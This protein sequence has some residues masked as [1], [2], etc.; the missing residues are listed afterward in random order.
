MIKKVTFKPY[1]GV[2]YKGG[3]DV[4]R[5]KTSYDK[6]VE[7]SKKNGLPLP[8]YTNREFIGWWLEAMKDFIGTWPTCGR[9][10]HKK[11]YS[12]DN[13]MLQ[14]RKDNSSEGAIRTRHLRRAKRF[15][16]VLCKKTGQHIATFSNTYEAADFFDVPRSTFGKML[17]NYHEMRFVKQRLKFDFK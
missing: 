3:K 5:A 7:R 4:K 13:I 14:D 16:K 8:T 17:L 11:G 6:Q 1:S 9:I 2:I 12:F 10:D 15:V